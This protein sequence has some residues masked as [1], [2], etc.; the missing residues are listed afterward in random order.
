MSK[1]EGAQGAGR[2]VKELIKAIVAGFRDP[3]MARDDLSF[4]FTQAP[5]VFC[6][7]CKEHIYYLREP[8]DGDSGPRYAPTEKHKVR[9]DIICP[10][11]GG[12]ICAYM[13]GVNMVRTDRGW[14]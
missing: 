13:E 11:C 7:R 10:A 2:K 6:I 3:V 5:K 4:R 14:R 9:D 8:R 12:I 1:V